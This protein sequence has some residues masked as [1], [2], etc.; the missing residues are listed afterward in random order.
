MRDQLR[1]LICGIV[2][3]VIAAASIIEPP[4]VVE[5]VGYAIVTVAMLI[6]IQRERRRLRG[7]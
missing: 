5:G 6:T 1:I 4:G 2:I 3:V 7:M